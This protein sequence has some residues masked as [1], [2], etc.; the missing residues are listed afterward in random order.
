M[1]DNAPL[2]LR[3]LSIR[4]PWHDA[5]W[6]G[7]VCD[8]P[9][10]N[11]A[12]LRLAN[13]HK[14][15]NDEVEVRLAGRS[16]EEMSAAQHPPCVA[17]RATFM[18]PFPL[19]RPVQHP[20]HESS[21]AYGHYKPTPLTV[22]AYAAGCVPFRW[23]LRDNAQE[24]SESLD[25][26]FHDQAEGAARTIMGFDSA[27]VQNVDNQRRLLDGFFSAVQPN[28]S[29]AF[30][31]AKE[32][33]FVEDPRRILIGV[34]WV[35]SVG[36]ALEYEYTEPGPS[37]SLIW[38]RPVG[39]SI[40]PEMLDGFL[41]PYHA[42]LD[43]GALDPTFDPADVAVFVPDEAFEQYSYGSEH[44]S[45]DQAIASLLNV[46]D[47]LQRA[48]LLLG[49]SQQNAL[50]WSSERLGELWRMRGPFPGLGAALHA[51]GVDHANL[52]A[53]RISQRVAENEDPWPLVD[54]VIADPGS[55]GAEWKARI[56]PTTAKKYAALATE[57]R[58][59]LH[60]VARFDL[61][62]SQ[63]ERFYVSEERAAA[64]LTVSDDEILANP[65]LLYEL[66]REA[67][68][69]I[70]VGSVDRG[71]YPAPSVAQDH[72]VPEPSA[73]TEAIDAR[74]VRSLL[75]SALES[76]ASNGD[77][78][79]TQDDLVRDVRRA[80]LD[81]PCPVDADLLNVIGA[82][83][84]PTIKE[85]SLGDGRPGLQ[86][87]RLA[88]VGD[89]I[90]AEVT[91]RARAKK[92][93]EVNADWPAELERLLGPVVVGDVDERRAREEKVAALEELAAARVGVLIGPAGTGKTT[94]LAALCAQPAVRSS[95]ILL[96]APTGKARVQLEKG[97]SRAGDTPRARTIAEFLVRSRR[98]L[99]ETGAYRR[100]DLPPVAEFGTVIIDEA[101]MLTEVQ[102]DAVLDGVANVQRLILVGDP[103]QLP[104][105]GAG[106]PFVDIVH[107]LKGDA[108]DDFPRVGPCFAE[109]TVR[110]RQAGLDRDDL[111]LAEW[112]G[113]DAPSPLADEVWSRILAGTTS[114]TVRFEQWNDPP[115]VF[116][117]L[118]RVLND[119]IEDIEHVEDEEGFGVSLGGVR[120][121]NGGV[122]FNNEWKDRPGSGEAAERWQVLSPVRGRAH[123]VAELNRSIQRRF[124]SR[125]I[126][127]ASS[128]GFGRRTPKP[129][130]PEGIVYGDKVIN[131]LNHRHKHVW[132]EQRTDVTPPTDS[133]RYVANGEIGMV[134]GHFKRGRGGPMPKNL[135]VEFS[136]QPGFSYKFWRSDLPEEGG[137]KLELAYAV[138]IHKS[139]GSEFG[140]TFLVLPNPCRLLSRELLYTALTRQ[141]EKVVVLHQGPLAEVLAYSSVGN[142][143]TA[144]RLTSLFD[145]PLPKEVQG[146]YLEDRLIHRTADG[147]LVRSK[148]EVIIADALTSQ[149]VEYQYE[150]PFIGFDGTQRLPDFTIDY[151]ATGE[152]FVWEHLGML[153][154]EK[155]RHSWER[156]LEWY[157][158]SGVLPLADGGGDR[159][160]LI[161]TTDDS[162]GGI[163]S[164]SVHAMIKSVFT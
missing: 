95:G 26:V 9:L 19:S 62:N 80:P 152:T 119:E 28:A 69:P 6:R 12:C 156:K 68:D 52:L 33:P 45:H 101:S 140:I 61:S 159:A 84:E 90:R 148:S 121:N 110:R 55:L 20:Y 74:R 21:S 44:V 53:H 22:P 123:G 41:L 143:E 64:G 112:F 163:D 153:S 15:R 8:D 14:R 37:R 66:D 161:V 3:H 92:R 146:R 157:A 154:V 1:P 35:T 93:H 137:G 97:F 126:E 105:I 103:R 141:T 70:P 96:L 136:T 17:E 31:Y 87:E 134:V 63:A 107:F 131:V 104:P 149:G 54:R 116:P 164:A 51:F 50:R 24:I 83:F 120:G 91:K 94:L 144:R 79:A 98:Y 49:S 82:E 132:P 158:R 46:I 36:E 108:V 40:R 43:R 117:L 4:V 5:G 89:G 11:S 86:L 88:L 23:L 75:V 106:R 127:F 118:V 109:L 78:L 59:L 73:M 42:A 125:A 47:G 39:H 81:P 130:G 133:L 77:T 151:A 32:V 16:I 147:H 48:E 122:F 38:E 111:A 129:M 113:G 34:G 57:R 10:S 13:V 155:Y 139:Q 2:P 30:F 150:A 71:V 142:S 124:R 7:T 60:L 99:P 25:L 102:L 128:T 115:D 29:L 58:A 18:A 135:E 67:V 76:R 100:S 114:S 160:T 72:P 138:T 65:Y 27:W 145:R 85:A 162:L 56:G